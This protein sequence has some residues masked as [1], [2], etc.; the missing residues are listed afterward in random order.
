MDDDIILTTN[1]LNYYYYSINSLNLREKKNIYWFSA[2]I[3]AF[4]ALNYN[5]FYK[6][7]N[8]ISIY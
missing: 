7:L 1:L 8:F 4:D 3:V 2:M 6:I 5:Y